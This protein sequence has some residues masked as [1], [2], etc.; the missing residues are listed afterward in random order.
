MPP[1]IEETTTG[2][3]TTSS[4]ESFVCF[5]G[6]VI[7]IQ[8]NSLFVFVSEP[9]C[10]MDSWLVLSPHHHISLPVLSAIVNL[11]FTSVPSSFG[12]TAGQD[13]VPWNPH[14]RPQKEC[15]KDT[16]LFLGTLFFFSRKQTKNKRET[17]KRYKSKE[18]T[19]LWTAKEL[20]SNSPRL[21]DLTRRKKS[22]KKK[23]I[24]PKMQMAFFLLLSSA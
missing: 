6:N 19:W 13:S 1:K 7:Q 5:I 2:R 11:F 24:A 15:N 16:H 23:E 3:K 8:P 17:F 22:L 10:F 14:T 20:W 18:K 4:F 9:F 21:T 12:W